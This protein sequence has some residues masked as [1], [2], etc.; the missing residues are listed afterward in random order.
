MASVD[1]SHNLWSVRVRHSARS[2]SMLC[3]P[4]AA[5][6]EETSPPAAEAR[7]TRGSSPSSARARTLCDLAPRPCPRAPRRKRSFLRPSFQADWCLL[8]WLAATWRREPPATSFRL[9]N[10]GALASAPSPAMLPT[11][12]WFSS[13]KS[14]SDLSRLVCANFLG[15]FAAPADDGPQVPEPVVPMGPCDPDP[16]VLRP[17]KREQVIQGEAQ[18]GELQEVRTS[19][20]ETSRPGV[21][22]RRRRGRTAKCAAECARARAPK[23]VSRGLRLEPCAL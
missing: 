1:R 21:R 7:R 20:S 12:P 9:A 23:A 16:D 14:A 6:T 19:R 10:A 18:L 4:Q 13:R 3:V 22:F 17:R 2:H 8:P 5:S 15:G 11:C